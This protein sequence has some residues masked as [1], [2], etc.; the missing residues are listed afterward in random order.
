MLAEGSSSTRRKEIRRRRRPTP[1]E[2]GQA[3]AELVAG[4]P[5]L[6]LAGLVA[7]QLLAAGYALTLADGAVEAGTLALAGG[8]PPRPAVRSALPG[9]A[10]AGVDVEVEGG[11][12]S[13][14]VRPPSPL[15]VIADALEVRS[16][17]WVRPPD[18]SS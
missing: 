13:V 16:S 14:G 9:W 5:I 2:R 11:R 7:L 6:V 3:S 12:V 18:G 15:P 4:L 1:G 17:A 10:R 8:K